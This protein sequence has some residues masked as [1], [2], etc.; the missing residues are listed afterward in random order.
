MT[1]ALT[2]QVA[3]SGATTQNIYDLSLRLPPEVTWALLGVA[4][5]LGTV[6]F[7]LVHGRALRM[8]LR[9]VWG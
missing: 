5:I 3:L 9:R 7:T 1:P 6:G 4:L 2:Q 8:G